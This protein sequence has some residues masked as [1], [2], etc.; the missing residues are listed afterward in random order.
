MRIT[1]LLHR[2]QRAGTTDW[3]GAGTIASSDPRMDPARAYADA[4]GAAA[5]AHGNADESSTRPFGDH[6]FGEYL[7]VAVRWSKTDDERQHYGSVRLLLDPVGGDA[8]IAKNNGRTGLCI[9]GGPLRDEQLRATN[10]CLRVDDVTAVAL[11]KLVE[12]ELTAGC[13]V[14]YVCEEIAA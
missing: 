3:V 10:G 1:A 2:Y 13:S 6:P 4:D 11:A 5:V 12:P 7:V 14:H 8:L 9:H